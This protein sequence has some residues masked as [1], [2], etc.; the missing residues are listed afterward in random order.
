MPAVFFF[1]RCQSTVCT[2][3]PNLPQSLLAKGEIVTTTELGSGEKALRRR[4]TL[5][6]T[7]MLEV[8][9]SVITTFSNILE[10]AFDYID[11]VGEFSNAAKS[12]IKRDI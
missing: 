11:T 12:P 6:K 3:P 2:L 8:L 9:Q 10:V 4:T 1:V 7:P 5:H